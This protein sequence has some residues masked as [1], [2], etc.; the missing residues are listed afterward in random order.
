MKTFIN[1]L[2]VLVSSNSISQEIEYKTLDDF[3]VVD[4]HSEKFSNMAYTRGTDW[5]VTQVDNQVVFCDEMDIEYFGDSLPFSLVAFNFKR[6]DRIIT[7]GTQHY[8]KV[9]NG[10]W[11]IGTNRG[12]WGGSMVWIAENLKSYKHLGS[13][14]VN[15][16]FYWNDEI[17]VLVG[18]SHLG[19][20]DGN[21]LRIN[22]DRTIDT[23]LIF[24][25]TPRAAHVESDSSF[26]LIT[27]SKLLKIDKT[28]GQEVLFENEEWPY[29]YLYASSLALTDNILY[30]AT[31]GRIGCF[32]LESREMRWM[33]LREDNDE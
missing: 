32:N 29:H 27:D 7:S 30:A 5:V 11:L 9:K 13:A 22:A 31:R 24:E 17:F 23:V 4:L 10:G 8:L 25:D 15:Q 19:S 21:I 16:F 12:E 14:N 2:L 26:Y 6:D 33:V 20:S 1:I 28:Y 3:E 18:L